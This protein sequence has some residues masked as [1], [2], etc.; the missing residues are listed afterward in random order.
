MHHS[1]SNIKPYWPIYIY[2]LTAFIT[3]SSC[4]KNVEK[5]T[6]TM[7]TALSQEE[8][9]ITFENRLDD[10]PNTNILMYEYFYNGGGVA[11][12][13]YNNDGLDDLYFTSN[14]N[15]NALYINEGNMKFR[16]I[17]QFSGA[18][19]RPGPW[20]TGVTAVDINSD[21]LLDI[22]VSYSGMLP[23]EK[24]VNQLFVNQGIN[25]NGNPLFKDMAEDYGLN[26]SAYS[27]QAYFLDYDTDGDI[28]M[29]QLNHN[30]KNLPILNESSTAALLT[31]DDPEIGL[32]LFQQNNGKFKDVT[33][34][35][36]INGSA[37]SYGLGLGISDVNQD[38]W[39]DF[40]VS[41]DYTVADY[42]YI[43]N[44]NGTFTNQVQSSLSYTSQ[45]S[46][47]NDVADY[48]N[49]GLTD[50]FTLD[51]LP[52][53]N[54]R[55]KLLLA[56]DNYGKF[57]QNVKNGFY[58]QYMRNMLHLNN[59]NG[60]FSEIGQLAGISNTD[61]SWSALLADYDNDGHKDLFVSNGYVRDYTNMDFTKY[62]ENFTKEK[63]RLN[64]DDILQLIQKMPASNVSNYIF[65][66]KGDLT[67][68]NKTKDWGMLQG[69]NST[70]AAY[71]DLDNDGDL[72]LVVNNINQPPFIFKNNN[73][74]NAY[75]QLSLK[76]KEGNSLALGSK[77]TVYK[78]DKI[79]YYEQQITRGYLSSVSPTLHIGLSDNQAID[80]IKIVWPDQMV[81]ILKNVVANKRMV[82][83]YK[84]I[85][86]QKSKL[87]TSK[88]PTLFAEGATI[89]PE[90]S[91]LAVN[92]FD[93]QL[94][95][96]R[97]FSQD[98]ACMAKGDLN[99]DGREDLFVGGS[100]NEKAAIYI[101]DK[102]GKLIYQKSDA[103]ELDAKYHDAAA[104]IVD[105][106]QDGDNDL[107]VASGGYHDL[108]SQ[109]ERLEDRL[110]LND[111]KGGWS[112]QSLPQSA[113]SSKSCIAV[114]DI[115]G[116]GKSDL[117]IGGRLVPGNYPQSPT[118]R[119]LINN[120]K[121]SFTNIDLNL[122]MITSVKI[123][124]LD[125]DK[126]PEL[127]VVGEWMPVSVFNFV[128]G[129]LED[130]T[131]KYFNENY[132]GWWN[133]LALEDMNGDGKLDIIAGNQGTNTQVKANIKEPAEMVYGDFDKNG[134]VDPLLN[135]YIQGVQ[136][137]YVTKEELGMKLPMLNK[138][139]TS[140]ESYSEVT[141]DNLLSDPIFKNSKKL[142]ATHLET[143][144]FLS[145]KDQKFEN[146]K[147]P[148]E[149]QFAPV[150]T[151]TT[152]D[153]N[154]DGFTDLLFTGNEENT[155]I[156]LGKSL[157]NYGTL[158]QNDGKGNFS[159][160]PF[161]KS[162]LNLKE[163][164]KSTQILGDK[165]LFRKSDGNIVSYKAVK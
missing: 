82:V 104:A 88:T 123:A 72:D 148:L 49:D 102:N 13:D 3:F 130:Q 115:N 83:D 73:K 153:F 127:V 27:N 9:G 87:P 46:M 132:Y 143:M 61:W 157:A 85:E 136:Y 101:Q 37:L 138:K 4:K 7:F 124:D 21:G 133:T 19:G 156:R 59:G 12:G 43:N 152:L 90:N 57:E 78:K 36:G 74:N 111:G 79:Q 149:V 110:Y 81:S 144:L 35:S 117:F 65:K 107:V 86:K 93:R 52:E 34:K 91:P 151:I 80:S 63:G 119:I 76:G 1:L 47:G 26:T 116:D 17:T 28:D 48:N 14:M 145:T 131:K 53:D 54:K 161:L 84:N 112:K 159:F 89:H 106:D 118:S 25:Q 105:V 122:G 147:L 134:S 69:S 70:G 42:L 11:V 64:R 66:N 15:D 58:Y 120:G 38:G 55:Q 98:A 113:R 45:F 68:D 100:L 160:I 114:G 40:Y 142:R 44:K 39:P 5:A 22:H 60:S 77:I 33:V 56:A 92:D 155:K 109:D 75:L 6:D 140:F 103:I 121:G 8:T 32:R 2:I 95:L 23:P 62:M 162:G 164:I 141:S 30:P 146:K 154:K 108:T 96:T 135:F 99:Q 94:L 128:N 50:I 125:N 129:K 51:M 165:L 71:T 137:P 29:L 10:G 97:A 139:Y 20:K 67:F 18:I 16:D 41:N 158:L 24:R 31:K 150:H 163:S 126:K